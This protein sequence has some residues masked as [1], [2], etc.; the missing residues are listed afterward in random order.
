M[1]ASWKPLRGP[2]RGLA[3]IL[4]LAVGTASLRALADDAGVFR[5]LGPLRGLNGKTLKAAPPADGA[6][7]VVFYSSECP[8][9]NAYSPTLNQ[10]FDAF[11]PPRVKWF[12]VCVDPDLSEADVTAHARDFG[13]KLDVVLDRRGAVAR[14]LGATMTPEAYVI[15]GQGKV[16]YHG[17]IDDQFAARGVRNAAAA[18]PGSELKDALGAVLSGSPVKVEYVKPVGC[19]IPVPAKDAAPTYSKDVARVLQQNCQE[20]HRKGQVGPFALE[21]YEQARKR[22]V[23]LASVVEDRSMPPWKAAPNVGPKFQHDRSLSDHDVQTIAAWAEAGAPEG[24][25]ADLPP[26]RAFPHDWTMEGGPDLIV[27]IGVDFEVPATGDDIY[28]CFVIPTNLPEDV[29]VSGI[30]YAPGNSRVVHH[31]LGYVETKGLARKRDAEE[32]GPGYTSFSGPGVPV[33]G[34]LGGWAPGCRP[35]ILPDGVGRSLPKNADVVVQVHYHPNGKAEVDRTRVGLRFARK[36]VRQT[37]HWN[38]AR[39]P[40]LKLPPGES[41][42]EVKATWTAPVDLTA[43]AVAPHMHLLGKDML[44]TLTFPDGRTQDLIK[45]NDWDFKWQYQYY[46]EQPIEIPKGTVLNVTAHF[47]NSSSNSRNPNRDAPQLV[48]WGEATT[49]EMCIGFIALTKKG[50]DLTKPGEKDDLNEIFRAQ[51]EEY[52]QKAEQMARDKRKPKAK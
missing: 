42:V 47:D 23:D 48:T 7:V 19:P 46:L 26:P 14:K 12:G 52:R 36:P 24:D 18:A 1:K 27:D 31:L 29:Y 51:N 3:L 8:I 35:S 16:R 39:N 45:I 20:C 17:R 37:L 2:L 4:T 25:P 49:D 41:N 33:N 32:P 15:D 10:L 44:M 11:P 40:D 50:Q 21:T 13:L 34:D 9:S 30:E 38:A 43:Y 5:D 6:A 22:A 28:R